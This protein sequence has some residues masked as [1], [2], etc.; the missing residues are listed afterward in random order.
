MTSRSRRRLRTSAAIAHY[1]ALTASILGFLIWA[2]SIRYHGGL[3]GRPFNRAYSISAGEVCIEWFTPDL[4]GSTPGF[5]NPGWRLRPRDEFWIRWRPHLSTSAAG[6]HHQIIIPF[7]PL[8]LLMGG[9]AWR[10]RRFHRRL[11]DPVLCPS[12]GYSHEGLPKSGRCP[13]C[14]AMRTFRRTLESWLIRARSHLRPRSVTQSV[15]AGLTP[16][17]A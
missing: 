3:V 1:L 9:A 7:W 13:E 2:V 10:L 15:S 6:T 14:G 12:C 4:N 17:S 11:S 8:P 16:R 5:G